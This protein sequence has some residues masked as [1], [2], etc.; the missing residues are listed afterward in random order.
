[1]YIGHGTKTGGNVFV[2]SEPGDIENDPEGLDEH[3]EPNPDKEIEKIE[4]D[5][6]K[7]DEDKGEENED[8]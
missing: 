5:T 1:V 4:V 6:D 3:P 7:E 2:P 8:E